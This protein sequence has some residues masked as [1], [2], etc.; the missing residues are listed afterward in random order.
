MSL[1]Q[2]NRADLALPARQRNISENLV[3]LSIDDISRVVNLAAEFEPPQSSRPMLG[4]FVTWSRRQVW[5][6]LGI[7]PKQL[8]A[9]MNHF[10][11]SSFAFR[12]GTLDRDIYRN[13]VLG[14]EYRL[15]RSFAPDDIVIDIGMHIGSFCFAALLRG[16]C[17]IHGFEPERKNFQLAVRNLRAFGER[18]HLHHKAVWR[19]DRTGDT[20]YALDAYAEGNTNTGGGCILYETQGQKLELIAFDDIIRI[21]TNNGQK[22]VRLVK[23]DCEGSEFP[24]LMTSQ[25]LH[26]VDNIHGEYHDGV[27]APVAWVNGVKEFRMESL[28]R[29]LQAA[30]FAVQS[31]PTNDRLGTFFATR[32]GSRDRA[33]VL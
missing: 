1:A 10:Y 9:V 7:K 16:C 27:N 24:I 2:E 17:N 29:H 8:M 32:E 22:R 6:L 3:G 23:I 11:A 33:K 18:V 13:V 5:R 19:S 20:L 31:F 28:A 25:L 30:G 12:E 21:V 4:P 15:P 26:L 14:N